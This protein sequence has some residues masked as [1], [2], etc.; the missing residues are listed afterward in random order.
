[1]PLLHEQFLGTAI[2]AGHPSNT[3]KPFRLMGNALFGILQT[4]WRRLLRIA[5]TTLAHTERFRYDAHAEFYVPGG[6]IISPAK[7]HH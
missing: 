4:P 2:H 7:Q 5:G 6:S 1:M 3:Y